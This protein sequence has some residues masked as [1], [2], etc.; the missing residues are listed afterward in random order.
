M[1]VLNGVDRL[2][3][4]GFAQLKGRK[5]G[6]VCNQATITKS[7]IHILDAML[8]GH[9]SSEFSIQAVFGPQH[10]IW[11]HTQDNMIEWE[12]YRDPRT[13][14]PFYSLY[15]EHRKPPIEWLNGI[16]LLVID[17][18]DVGSRYYTFIWTTL[19][20]M[21]ACH[22]AGIPVLVLDRVNP[23]G[24]EV[25]GNLMETGFESFV[26][27]KPL[28]M[29]HGMTLGEIARRFRELYAPCELSVL[30]TEGWD[31]VSRFSATDLMWAMPSPNMPT[32]DT[33]LVYPG[34]CL[35]EGTK[36]SEG[37]GTT[38]PFE[39]V[40]AEG[41]NGWSLAEELARAGLPG[42]VFR[43]IQFM[44][45]FQKY[46]GRVCEGV[47]V[48]V[49][50]ADRFRPC[51]TYLWLIRECVRLFPEVFEWQVP[52]YE[53]EYVLAPIDIL[54][55]TDRLRLMIERASPLP[56]FETMLGESLSLWMREN[57]AN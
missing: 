39:I 55:G 18:P 7:G 6:L 30:E 34:A 31:G 20:C 12:G 24:R 35:I 53:Y 4:G 47:F 25:E 43:P 28:P 17:L 57:S 8:P 38:R 10:G 15:G 14:I 9:H 32:P 23:I 56:D 48:H 22:E 49:T 3:R 26:G 45:T 44:P 33:A 52:P 40:G 41:F 29:R 51:L 27:L 5:I 1:N 36:L 42:V 13:G 46:A 2:I 54:C 21:E 50:D 19:L 11:G 16:D 37:R